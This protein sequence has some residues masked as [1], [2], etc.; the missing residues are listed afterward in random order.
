M[1]DSRSGMHISKKTLSIVPI[2]LT[3]ALMPAIAYAGGP[4]TPESSWV[5]FAATLTASMVTIY[6]VRRFA[7]W[8]TG[9]SVAARQNEA[10]N[11]AQ[12][13]SR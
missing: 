10:E 9:R 2:T 12:S 7:E 8:R 11:D 3:A 1:S 5:L 6:L 13:E 4:M